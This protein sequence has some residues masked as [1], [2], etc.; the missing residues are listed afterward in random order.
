MILEIAWSLLALGGLVRAIH[1]ARESVIDRRALG[2]DTNGRRLLAD[3]QVEHAFMG[4]AIY[5]CLLSAGL[6]ALGF[7]FDLIPLHARLFLASAFLVSVLLLL[8]TR[9][10]RDASYR[11]RTVLGRTPKGLSDV[12][13]DTNVRVREIQK[14]GQA[15]Q[16]EEQEDR[17]E[18]WI[19]HAHPERSYGGRMSRRLAIFALLVTCG[20]LLLGITDVV[21]IDPPPATEMPVKIASIVLSGVA[22]GAILTGLSRDE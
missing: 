7:R 6:S 10:E 2:K 9:Q 5:F 17:A 18:G 1:L 15:D 21:L 12:V 20:V 3:W 13:N 19:T 8:V 16:P 4:V 22:V 11:K 14:R